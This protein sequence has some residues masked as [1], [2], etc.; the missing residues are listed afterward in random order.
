[1]LADHLAGVHPVDVVGAEHDDVG[2]LL[3]A[4][5]VEALVDRVGR[6]GEP[7]RPESLLRRHRGDVVPE[8]RG[9]P[10]GGGDVPVQAVALVLREHHDLAVAGIDQVGQ[11]EVDEPVDPPEGHGWLRAVGGQRH[12]PLALTSR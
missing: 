1:V 11:D 12:Q 8:H 2:G 9:Q 3:V 10:P 4:D 6:P 7:P 5:Q